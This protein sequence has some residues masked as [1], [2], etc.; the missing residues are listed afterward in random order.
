MKINWITRLNDELFRVDYTTW[1]G[2]NRNRYAFR[3]STEY[4]EWSWRDTTKWSGSRLCSLFSWM[5]REDVK[6]FKN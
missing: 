3:S 4:K 2:L 6:E 1:Y 5:C